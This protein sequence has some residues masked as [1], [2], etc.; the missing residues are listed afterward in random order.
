MNNAGLPGTGVGGFLYIFLA[1]VMPFVELYRT[2][3]G[4]SS[5][6]NWKVVVRQLAIALGIIASIEA[7]GFVLHRLFNVQLRSLQVIGLDVS[8]LPF[9]LAAPFLLSFLTLLSVFLAIRLWELVA[10]LRSAARLTD[11]TT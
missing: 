8:N 3:R 2:L 11:S 5:L 4:R 1:F 9:F 10:R 6:A 7:T